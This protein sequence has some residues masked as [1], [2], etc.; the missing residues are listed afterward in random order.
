[1]R[2]SIGVL[3]F[4]L[5]TFGASAAFAQAESIGRSGTV[6][7]GAERLFSFYKSNLAFEAPNG[8]ESDWD[9]SGLGFGWGGVGYQ[10]PF[11]MARLGFDYFLTDQLSIGGALGYASVDDEDDGP[12][13]DFESFLLA[14]RVG[15]FHG[16]SDTFGIWPRGGFT[17]HSLDPDGDS[18][19]QWGLALTLEGMFTISPAPHF[20]FMLGPTFDMDFM[21]KQECG[22]PNNDESCKLRYRSFGIQV[23]LL[24]WF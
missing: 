20:A 1:M 9:Q 14:P 8:D 5:V 12:S 7:F 2:R 15:Y 16:F 6:A 18:N 11:N 17:Y 22:G 4:S 24:G 10:F 21:G 23:G 13:G 19:N 3:A